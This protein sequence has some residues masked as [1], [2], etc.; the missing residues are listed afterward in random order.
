MA[1]ERMKFMENSFCV[2]VSYS[3]QVPYLMHVSLKMHELLKNNLGLAIGRKTGELTRGICG[4]DCYG[5]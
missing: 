3:Q 1:A 2:V 5:C 4:L